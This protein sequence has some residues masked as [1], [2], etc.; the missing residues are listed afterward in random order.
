M[1]T[2][3]RQELVIHLPT[4][5]CDAFRDIASEI[6]ESLVMKKPNRKQVSPLE[7]VLKVEKAL[8]D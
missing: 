4:R 8:Q 2:L 3:I 7:L 5:L 6:I 1:G